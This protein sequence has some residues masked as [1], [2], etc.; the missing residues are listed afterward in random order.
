[1]K[2]QF[3]LILALA[4]CL[5][6]AGCGS[7]LPESLPSGAAEPGTGANDSQTVPEPQET[8]PLQS[9][10]AEAPET[11]PSEQESAEPSETEPTA[12]EDK[13][14][15]VREES[16]LDDGSSMGYFLTYDYNEHGDLIRE[17]NYYA[18]D[19]EPTVREYR[20]E[21]D[22]LGN[23]IYKTQITAS[24]DSCNYEYT[25]DGS[26][27]TQMVET[28][29][30]SSGKDVTTETYDAAG[31]KLTHVEESFNNSDTLLK[32]IEVSYTRDENGRV[33]TESRYNPEEDIR[34]TATYSYDEH[35]RVIRRS[36]D[37]HG[38]YFFDDM[39][40]ENEYNDRGQLV[41]VLQHQ[42]WQ[43]DEYLVERRYEYHENGET[44]KCMTRDYAAMMGWT[45]M[46]YDEH[47]NRVLQYS[48]DENMENRQ[49]YT[50]YSYM[51]LSEY[52][53]QKGE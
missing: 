24:V 13:W 53:A 29:W 42:Y 33:L 5:L 39:S 15:K 8:D 40:Y 2:K 31:R 21:Y 26:H 38:S 52:L 23:M 41:K 22:E 1:M 3:I 19:A 28:H 47:G 9:E 7:N 35:G 10:S 43:G 49:S 34:F 44:S 50:Q 45:V 37:N 51:L 32:R 12:P 25:Y 14:V 30:T 18:P 36:L 16:F 27:I 4:L 6:L 46:E 20:Y 11:E 17:E 48:L